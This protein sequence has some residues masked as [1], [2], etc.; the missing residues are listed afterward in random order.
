MGPC[1]SGSI[2]HFYAFYGLEYH[3]ST[4]M[5]FSCVVRTIYTGLV[6]AWFRIPSIGVNS[7]RDRGQVD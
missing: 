3:C 6:F 1:G 5:Y 2:L 4:T 7:S